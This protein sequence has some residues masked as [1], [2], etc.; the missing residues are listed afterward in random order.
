LSPIA[1]RRR[2]FTARAV[3]GA[4]GRDERAIRRAGAAASGWP[5]SCDEEGA[6][7]AA[8]PRTR[9]RKEPVMMFAFALAL[10]G[11]V[12]LGSLDIIA[13]RS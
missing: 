11:V 3:A 1:A 8:R 7:E 12:V 10:V 13:A 4:S 9:S 5:R 2:E 6:R